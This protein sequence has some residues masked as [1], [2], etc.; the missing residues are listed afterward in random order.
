WE[1]AI[2]LINADLDKASTSD[3]CTLWGRRVV[4]QVASLTSSIGGCFAESGDV[5][6]AQGTEEFKANDAVGLISKK[7]SFNFVEYAKKATT[8]VKYLKNGAEI[9]CLV[10]YAPEYVN[11]VN[12]T[13]DAKIRKLEDEIEIEEEKK[14][15]TAAVQYH[16]IITSDSE[17]FESEDEVESD[18]DDATESTMLNAAAV[19]TE[20]STFNEFKEKVKGRVEGDVS[21]YMVDSV[22]RAWVQP[23]LQSKIEGMVEHY[24]KKTFQAIGSM[25]QGSGTSNSAD[26]GNNKGDQQTANAENA[27]ADA[28]KLKDS[29]GEDG[30]EI[31]KDRNGNAIVEPKTYEEVVDGIGGGK[32]A[33]LLEMQMIA[34]ALNCKLEIVDTVGDFVKN[35]SGSFKIDPE[36]KA[37]GTIQ[38]KYTANE[39]GTKH[40][41]LIGPD[42][43]EIDLPPA[44]DANGQPAP[45]NR[46]LY[47]AVAKAQN[48]ST[49]QLLDQVKTHA[50]GNKMARYLY[51]EK[52]GEAC[53]NLRV[54]REAAPNSKP[55]ESF[56]QWEDWEDENNIHRSTLRTA[57]ATIKKENIKGG[58][59][60]TKETL[61]KMK[62]ILRQNGISEENFAD[63][64]GGHLIS[65]SSGG[66]GNLEDNNIVPMV[67]ELNQGP[68]KGAEMT[69]LN[70][71]KKMPDG[72]SVHLNIIINEDI[73]SES[74]NNLMPA[75]FR[76]QWC[77][78]D[79]QTF[80]KSRLFE[81]NRKSVQNLR[82]TPR[83][84]SDEFL[85]GE[86]FNKRLQKQQQNENYPAPSST[87]I[88][89]AMRA[90]P[91]PV[92]R[93]DGMEVIQRQNQSV[94]NLEFINFPGTT[95]DPSS[96]QGYVLP[97]NEAPLGETRRN[98]PSRA[99]Q[100]RRAQQQ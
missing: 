65:H 82:E 72:M 11:N 83:E 74:A 71:L 7:T 41:T 85:H 97:S 46:C 40:V 13:L 24:G 37:T 54:G 77:S 39:D 3:L 88:I 44:I 91:A 48:C 52:V 18:D 42:G 75:N 76:L 58:S 49:D 78:S 35:R 14:K 63:Y 6:K 2:G 94:I 61:E 64:Q 26:Q 70:F 22:T 60:S 95:S 66:S 45:P 30:C 33:G 93:V 68:Y 50:T 69:L 79:R 25:W 9:L 28:E 96:F 20:R 86:Y 43:K 1:K 16:Q 100:E 67:K 38:V 21:K 87:P 36:G 73:P 15:S 92:E 53:P 19:A 27:E 47:D 31:Q 5:W 29:L 89:A 17:S 55:V 90:E 10:S 80:Y 57:V 98:Q 32:T 81:N 4:G 23:W 84:Q 51:D 12:Q 99:V 62:E 8:V 59:D 56:L 34:D